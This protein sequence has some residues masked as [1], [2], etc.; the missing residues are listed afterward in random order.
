MPTMHSI[1]ALACAMAASS[2]SA[3]QQTSAAPPPG[4]ISG[5]VIDATTSAP[6]ARATVTLTSP[7]GLLVDPRGGSSPLA[8]ARTVTTSGAGAYR[9]NALPIGAYRLRI[10]RVGYE[11]ATIDVR[12]GETGSSPVSIG[13]VVLPV[14]LRA[15]EVRAHDSRASASDLSFPGGDDSRVVAARARQQA[16]LSTDARELTPA[17]VAESATIGGSDVLRSMQRLPGVT[18]LDDWSAELWVRGNRWDHNRVYFDDLPLFDPLGVLG[19]TSGVSANA[20]GGAFLHPGVRP[21]SLGGEG[22][23]RI[24]LRSRPASTNGDWRGSAELAQFGASMAIENERADGSAGLLETAQ[25]SLGDWLPRDAFF[26][27]ALSGRTYTDMQVTNRIEADLSGGA[28]M[29]TSGLYTR[30]SRTSQSSAGGQVTQDWR[31]VAQRLTFFAPVGSVATSHTIGFSHYTSNASRFFE[32]SPDTVIASPAVS[33]VDYFALSGRLD[34]PRTQHDAVSVGYDVITQRS[35]LAGTHESPFWLDSSQTFTRRSGALTY[36]SAWVDNRTAL[37]DRVTLED[38][39]RVDVGGGHGLDAVRLAGSAQAL[40]ALSPNTRLSTGASRSHQY[41]QGVDLPLVGQGQT[42]PTS[43][44]MSGGDVPVMTVD[45]AMAGIE[46]WV[47]AGTLLAANA[48]VRHTSG[49][50][51]NDPTPGSLLH[52]P[53]FVDATESAHGTEVSARQLNGRVTGFLDYSYSRATM[54]ARGLTFTAPADRTHAL[55]AGSFVHLGAVTLGGAYTLT[56]GAPYTRVVV[57]T[58][59]GQ[60]PAN[61]YQSAVR[62]APDALRLPN[63][64]S[65]DLSID[66][67]RTIR[68]NVVLIGFAGV[69]NVFDRRNLTWYELSGFCDTGGELVGGP[70]CRDHDVLEA[71]VKRAPTIGL[72][73]VVR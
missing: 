13:L 1:L 61:G 63:Y 2:A 16:F 26:N 53:L 8:L 36:G 30:D 56:S 55:N 21:V 35:S 22:A 46:Q 49:A 43:W 42:V 66:Y 50:V 3:Q 34:P 5:S 20:V 29:V 57:T 23:T 54:T 15:M 58:A 24:D 33:G 65:L 41:M 48:Y 69:Q 9:F 6:L 18:Q 11:P 45:N 4:T 19:R 12:L 31:N 52:R 72:R 73:L 64:A 70:Q 51:A 28:R 38:G 7:D 62:E 67:R 17:D 59:T 10:Q 44:L 14:R 37:G 68:D 25:H 27:E 39:I 32:V 60:V 40:F 47:G 71:P